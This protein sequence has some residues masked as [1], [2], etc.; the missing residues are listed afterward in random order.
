[1]VFLPAPC[2]TQRGDCEITGS[3]T[4]V[5]ATPSRK[6]RRMW[7]TSPAN[8]RDVYKYGWAALALFG[9]VVRILLSA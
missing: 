8:G 6:Q 2:V 1:M 9:R 4:S 3:G 7:Q 5:R